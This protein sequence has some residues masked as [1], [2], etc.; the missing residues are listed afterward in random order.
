MVSHS[1]AVQTVMI[2]ATA[3]EIWSQL[4]ESQITIATIKGSRYVQPI[5]VRLVEFFEDGVVLASINNRAFELVTAPFCGDI[6]RS[7]AHFKA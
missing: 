2:I 7:V 5:K 6:K 1:S 4:E 3:E